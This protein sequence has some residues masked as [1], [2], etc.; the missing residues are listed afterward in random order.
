VGPRA[1]LGTEARGKSE[2]LNWWKLLAVKQRALK[3]YWIITGDSKYW[4]VTGNTGNL[5][6]IVSL[7]FEISLQNYQSN[8]AS[9]EQSDDNDSHLS[10]VASSNITFDFY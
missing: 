2:V 7:N 6:Y 9:S 5:E 8:A 4:V 10:Y 1:G 3:K